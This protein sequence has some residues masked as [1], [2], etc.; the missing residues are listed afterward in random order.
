MRRST[1]LWTTRDGRRIRIRDMGD[2]HLANTIAMIER[3]ANRAFEEVLNSFP[4]LNGEMAQACAEQ[5]W[6]HA[7]DEGVSPSDISPLYDD[8]L[9]EYELRHEKKISVMD[10]D[11]T[12]FLPPLAPRIPPRNFLPVTTFS[13]VLDAHFHGENGLDLEGID[14]EESDV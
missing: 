7:V 11:A 2:R 10:D 13:D 6:E 5:D 9:A 8:L 4:H 1:K 14:D 3:A 12:K